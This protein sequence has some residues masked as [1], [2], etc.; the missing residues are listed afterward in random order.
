MAIRRVR[1]AP[2]ELA[3]LIWILEA[4][5]GLANLTEDGDTIVLA[6]PESRARELDAVLS[7]LEAELPSLDVVR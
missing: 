6:T 5:D 4:H 3:M 1:V 7:D 2:E